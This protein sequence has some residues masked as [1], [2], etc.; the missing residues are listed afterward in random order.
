MKENASKGWYK[1]FFT[2]WKW[3]SGFV[4]LARQLSTWKRA[5]WSAWKLVFWFSWFQRQRYFTSTKLGIIASM[6]CV[7]ARYHHQ[8]IYDCLRSDGKAFTKCKLLVI[9]LADKG[10]IL[11]CVCPSVCLRPGTSW[12]P[13]PSQLSSFHTTIFTSMCGDNITQSPSPPETT[14]ILT[15]NR[16]RWILPLFSL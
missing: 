1:K 2:Q 10:R 14:R 4:A 8:V 9:H 6:G 5:L 16:K 15:R 3:M 7:H 12:S 11:F 13:F